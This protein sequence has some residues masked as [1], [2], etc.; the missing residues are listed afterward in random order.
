MK[1]IIRAALPLAFCVS[2]FGQFSNATR[3]RGK[4]ICPTLDM[5]VGN[6]LKVG[7]SVCWESSAG[8]GAPSGAAG[9][10]LS[11]TYPNP[12]LS[13]SQSAGIT[14]AG[15]QVFNGNVTAGAASNVDLSGAASVSL[16]SLYVR[17][18][19]SFTMT[20]G[21]PMIG[22]PAA[23]F[24]SLQLIAGANPTGNW[25]GALNISVDGGFN[26]SPSNGVWSKLAIAG[27]KTLTV[28]H[29]MTLAGGDS[30][31]ITFPNATATALTTNAAVTVPQGGCGTTSFTAY[32]L[33]AGGTTSTGNCQVLAGLG[34]SGQVL[35]SNGAGALPTFQDAAGGAPGGSSTQIQFNDSGAFGGAAG[36]LYSVPAANRTFTEIRAGSA[37]DSTANHVWALESSDGT[38]HFYYRSL[39][40]A[41]FGDILMSNSSS[42]GSADGNVRITSGNVYTGYTPGNGQGF[43]SYALGFG[44][45]ADTCLSRST[46]GVFRISTGTYATYA[47]L[48]LKNITSVGGVVK[49]A[50]YT[51]AGLPTCNGGAEGSMAGATDL[52]TPTFLTAATGGGAVHGTVYCNG[53]AWVTN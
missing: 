30:S 8:G 11:G 34:T 4:P 27:G 47:D 25:P 6:V 52:L 21:N 45:T 9:G 28:S 42:I 33:I 10:V 2:V 50:L 36:L 51:V 46:A 1:W 49:L 23:A 41:G 22:T 5:T 32:A 15:S 39:G 53:S 26:Y 37:D 16:P 17:T 13:T 29:T 24:P 7:S 3:L 38:Q 44:Y 40:G 35:T 18:N 20:A 14:W 12:G 43:C 19:A 48:D 31:V